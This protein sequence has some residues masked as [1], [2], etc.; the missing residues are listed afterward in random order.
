MKLFSLFFVGLGVKSFNFLW[1]LKVP[2]TAREVSL[3]E[4]G[5][6]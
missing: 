2:I 5:E 4:Y 6:R 3:K 1:G